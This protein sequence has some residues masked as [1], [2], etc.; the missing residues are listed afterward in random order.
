MMY[1]V[2]KKEA[3]E[4]LGLHLER[5]T[6]IAPLAARIQA[7]MILSTNE[8]MTFDEIV[9]FTEAS[10]SSVSSN[11]NLLLQIKSVEYFTVSGERKRYFRSSK[12]RLCTRLKEYLDLVQEEILIVNQI[13]KFN[14]KYN[15]ACFQ[16]K[17]SL[18]FLFQD[19]LNQQKDI[20][21]S[22]LEKME[23]NINKL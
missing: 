1:S 20:I 23:Q 16:D 2:E 7:L 8:G 17:E 10:K 4:T 21:E 9:T 12:H 5:R 18:G 13:N 14:A 6:Q 3:V 15:N 11:L 19:F 22:T